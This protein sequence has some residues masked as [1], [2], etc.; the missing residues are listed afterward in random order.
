LFIP[1]QKQAIHIES[2]G[3]KHINIGLCVSST[4]ANQADWFYVL[5]KSIA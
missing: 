1:D 2:I 3:I 5:A 4:L